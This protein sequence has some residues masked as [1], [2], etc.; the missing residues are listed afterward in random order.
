MKLT[1]RQSKGT[2]K[3]NVLGFD[4]PFYHLSCDQSL[5]VSD[6]S[7]A[8]AQVVVDAIVDVDQVDLSY[9]IQRTV[10][11]NYPSNVAAL[12]EGSDAITEPRRKGKRKYQ[13]ER[14]KGKTKKREK[15]IR[16]RTPWERKKTK[17]RNSSK[18]NREKARK[19][20]EE[21]N[22]K[23]GRER[24]RDRERKRIKDG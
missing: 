22:V 14:E 15:K 13:R 12:A 1:A 23:Y 21:R 2:P 10:Q 4:Q 5:K 3:R 20:K 11:F 16:E 6:S 8:L 24:D 19:K 18:S 17:D 7:T 9:F